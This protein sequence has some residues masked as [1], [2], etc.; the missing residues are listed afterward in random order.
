MGQSVPF[1]EYY[2]GADGELT[3]I[4][5]DGRYTIRP[6]FELLYAHYAGV[7]GLNASWTG[8]YRDMVNGNSTDNVE[9]GGGDYGTTSGGY[10]ALGFG[11][12]L[13]RLS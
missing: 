4:S 11:T 10:D 2:S 9:G 12:L 1:T 7:K 6:G 13:Y 8:L 3:E 5:S